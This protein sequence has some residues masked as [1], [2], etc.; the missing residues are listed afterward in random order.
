MSKI[1]WVKLTE[2]YGQLEADNYQ[3][4]LNAY[5]IKTKLF[6]ES[7]G[8]NYGYPMSVGRFALVQ[9]YIKPSDLSLAKELINDLENQK[10]I[11][12]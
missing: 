10:N 2:V 5:G 8:K 6:Q 3:S 12:D 1:S 11:D 7:V 4:M 9:I